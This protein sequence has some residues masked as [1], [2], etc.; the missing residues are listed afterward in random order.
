MKSLHMYYFSMPCQQYDVFV[1]VI[2]QYAMSTIRI[3]CACILSVC[4]VNNAKF[5]TCISSVCPVKDPKW[6]TCIRY[7]CPVDKTNYL[8]V[9]S[10]SMPCQEDSVSV[11]VSIKRVVSTR[12]KVLLV[13]CSVPC[14]KH[15]LQTV[16]NR[17]CTSQLASVEN[18]ICLS[19]VRASYVLSYCC[20]YFMGYLWA[21]VQFC[22][23][24]IFATLS[25]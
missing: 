24:F 2:F 18:Y 5:F 17:R 19:L 1:H 23:K 4:L 22:M 3:V 9:Y 7:V 14:Q 11:H 20:N 13:L 16:F 12:L 8:Q 25:R 6:L 15:L 10:G 21:S